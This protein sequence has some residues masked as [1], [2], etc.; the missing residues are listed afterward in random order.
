MGRHG[1]P[2]GQRRVTARQGQVL[3]EVAALIDA[4]RIRSPATETA[5]RIDAATLRRVHAQIES[6]TARGKIVLE[7]F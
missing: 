4:S 2:L 3:N 6:G 7:G 5:G 1:V